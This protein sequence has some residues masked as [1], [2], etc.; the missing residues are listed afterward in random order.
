M[1]RLI[2]MRVIEEKMTTNFISAKEENFISTH[3]FFWDL[4]YS[5]PWQLRQQCVEQDFFKNRKHRDN[6][7]KKVNFLLQYFHSKK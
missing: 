4:Y 6:L 1:V 3:T 2:D 5:H 7:I